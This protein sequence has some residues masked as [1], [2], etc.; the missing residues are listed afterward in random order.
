[1]FGTYFYRA[2]HGFLMTGMYYPKRVVQKVEEMTGRVDSGGRDDGGSSG[3]ADAN[4]ADE[5]ATARLQTTVTS[6]RRELRDKDNALQSVRE[7][8]EKSESS[9]SKL[10][11]ENEGL[12]EKMQVLLAECGES[13]NEIARLKREVQEMR[14]KLKL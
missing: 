10:S 9:S 14:E 11:E 1:M 6:L 7:M 12:R 2:V 13:E 4:D 5:V 8:L 3:G